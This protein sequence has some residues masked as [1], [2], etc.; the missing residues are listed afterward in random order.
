MLTLLLLNMKQTL[1]I[2]LLYCAFLANAQSHETYE[3]R[4]NGGLCPSTILLY[5]NA[6]YVYEYGC[7]A[8]PHLSFGTWTKKKDTIKFTPVNPASFA[9]IKDIKATTV[10]GDS[11]W[12]LLLDKDGVNMTAKIS[13]GLDVSGRGAYM[14]SNDSSG[15]TKFVYKRSGG[16]LVLRTLGKL[17]GR[18]IELATD[19][20]NNFVITLNLSASWI[21]STHADWG[22]T[23]A[24]SLL[25]KENALLP[26]SSSPQQNFF[27]K[28]RQ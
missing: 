3:T 10:A 24:F 13:A 7:E 14:M 8:A 23:G 16:K 5:A 15:T 12:L 4:N 2:L 27:Q 11:I 6:D 17:F 22:G 25:K 1:L 28:P 26:L 21:T 18:R 20:A 19:T 9:V